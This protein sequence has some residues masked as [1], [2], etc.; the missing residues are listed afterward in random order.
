MRFEI[1]DRQKSVLVF[2]DESTEYCASCQVF[3]YGDRGFMYN[4]NG[5]QFYELWREPGT[6]KD[7]LFR[8]GVGSLEG[9]VTEAHARL[10][11]AALR[12][13][14][15]V[16]IESHGTMNGHPMVWVVVKAK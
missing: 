7:L 2:D 3:K 16:T 11:R 15:A 14:G 9:Y 12:H 13:V 4:I 5:R 6:L 1:L 8:L 10:M